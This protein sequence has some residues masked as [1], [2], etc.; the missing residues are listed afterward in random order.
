MR[1]SS[2]SVHS[3]VNLPRFTFQ[4][5]HWQGMLQPWLCRP[6]ELF[7]VPLDNKGTDMTDCCVQGTGAEHPLPVRTACRLQRVHRELGFSV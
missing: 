2:L 3:G 7:C 5:Q 6:P 4:H 1:K